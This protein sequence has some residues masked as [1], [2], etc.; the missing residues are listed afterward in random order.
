MAIPMLAPLLSLLLAGSLAVLAPLA[1]AA[2]IYGHIS[3]NG[4]ARS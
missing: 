1:R 2:H 3:R 4:G